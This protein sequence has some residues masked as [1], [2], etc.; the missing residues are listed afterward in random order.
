MFFD[1]LELVYHCCT[2]E[3]PWKDNKKNQSCIPEGKYEVQPRESKK[4]KKHFVLNGV[5][6]R[7]YILIHWGCFYYNT[8]GCILVGTEHRDI[9]QD[10][11]QDVINSRITFDKIRNLLKGKR[12]LTLRIC[13][14]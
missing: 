5:D 11:E 4:Y 10:G 14:T 7:S 2:I 6:G 12:D 8:T 3:P 13:Y 9:N 1:G